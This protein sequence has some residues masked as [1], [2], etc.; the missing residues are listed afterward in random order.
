MVSG[1]TRSHDM[2]GHVGV[3]PT[4]NGVTK[5]AETSVLSRMREIWR[6]CAEQGGVLPSEDALA[7]RLGTSKPTVR[8]ALVRLEAEGL[9]R[10]AQ[11]AGT[12]A[13]RGALDVTARLDRRLDYSEELRGAGFEP[14]VELIAAGLVRL[15][16]RRAGLLDLPATTWCLET[17]KRWR[18]DDRA[19]M[20]AVDLVPLALRHRPR[21][22]DVASED[23]QVPPTIEPTTQLLQLSETVGLGRVEWITTWPGAVA[24]DATVAEM[25]EI[26]E[27]TALLT[28]E[29]V[30][31]GRHGVRSFHAFEYHAAGFIRYALTVDARV[32]D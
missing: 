5:V 17:T 10:R 26:D 1:D 8:E 24:A 22:E 18:A 28:L 15:D 16:A 9:V 13:N 29:H 32:R 19:V 23:V 21:D 20:V 14:S 25:L 6:D 27:A 2:I 12:F 4:G 31:V 11:G 7:E 30:G 3:A